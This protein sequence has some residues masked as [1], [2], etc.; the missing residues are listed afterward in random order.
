MPNH[1]RKIFKHLIIY[2]TD[3][4]KVLVNSYFRT[5]VSIWEFLDKNYPQYRCPES[6]L[7]AMANNQV[8]NKYSHIYPF[9]KVS[10]VDK[11]E[12]PKLQSQIISA[13]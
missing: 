9:V 13:I 7:R 3:K 11:S 6:T 10:C 8:I 4:T 1:S 2:D 5:Y 12:L